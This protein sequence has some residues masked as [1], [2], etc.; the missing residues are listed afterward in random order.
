M[1]ACEG[2]FRC[3]AFTFEDQVRSSSAAALDALQQGSWRTSGPSRWFGWL[4]GLGGLFRD[5]ARPADALHVMMLTGDNVAS[6][7]NIAGACCGLGYFSACAAYGCHA[8]TG[9]LY[10]IEACQQLQGLHA[11]SQCAADT[12]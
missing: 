12:Q 10:G 8:P 9:E 4:P 5:Q 3:R 11:M 7:R 6:A 2:L 1:H